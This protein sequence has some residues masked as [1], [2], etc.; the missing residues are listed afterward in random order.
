MS[1]GISLINCMSIEILVRELKFKL[2]KDYFD[3]N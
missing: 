2:L 1:L 3:C